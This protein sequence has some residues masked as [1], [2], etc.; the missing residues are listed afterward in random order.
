MKIL[1][2]LMMAVEGATEL[3]KYCFQ[4]DD[5]FS[6]LKGHPERVNG[7]LALFGD[8]DCANATSAAWSDGVTYAGGIQE[9][10]Y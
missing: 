8:V 9:R 3:K 4:P 7:C 2:L 5:L 6:M 1:Y 10:F